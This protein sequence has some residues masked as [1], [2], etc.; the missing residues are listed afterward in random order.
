MW[1]A[2]L[3]C[4][5]WQI[6]LHPSTEGRL[7]DPLFLTISLSGLVYLCYL[8]LCSQDLLQLVMVCK[9]VLVHQPV[10]GLLYH[11]IL[12][13]Q[14]AFISELNYERVEVVLSLI[15]LFWIK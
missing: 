7:V 11:F 6:L 8:R 9:A 12:V 14:T 15:L 1:S 13:E 2:Y 10:K 4:H 5:A 3:P